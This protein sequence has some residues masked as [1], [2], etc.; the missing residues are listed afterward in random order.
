MESNEIYSQEG[1]R[2]IA[3]TNRPIPGQSLTNNP[4]TP[5]IWEGAPE[6]VDF[7]E[8]LQDVTTQLLK[9]ENMEPIL[10]AIND[11]VPIMDLVSQISYV[12][13]REGKFNP[14]L[15]LLLAE[16]LA[17]ILMYMSENAGIKYRI[18]SDDAASAADDEQEERR[19]A[20]LRSKNI[21]RLKK[22]E[23]EKKV[24]SV[25]N[26]LDKDIINQ[27]DKAQA[28]EMSSSLLAQEEAIGDE[29]SANQVEPNEQQQQASLLNR[30]EQ[31]VV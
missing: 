6:H 28:K 3:S 18:D 11:G 21:K 10:G 16:P 13:F 24:L 19:Y 9:P 22:Q 15:M 12:G 30:T 17:Y 23:A 5:Y 7:K 8:A 14:D 27:I 26:R 29:G 1:V 2:A 4:D 20:S 31:G 25:V